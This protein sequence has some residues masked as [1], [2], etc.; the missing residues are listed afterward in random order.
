[1]RGWGD[2]RIFKRLGSRVSRRVRAWRNALRT[3]GEA[4]RAQDR[5]QGGGGA[6]LWPLL[7]W[8]A[9]L[10]PVL[11]LAVFLRAREPHFVFPANALLAVIASDWLTF[12]PQ[13][14]S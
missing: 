10:P 5:G 14:R 1:M 2:Q 7:S 13:E 8:F 11:L 9:S 6:A 12:G 4:E 3:C